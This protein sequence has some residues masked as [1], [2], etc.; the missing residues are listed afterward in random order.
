[1]GEGKVLG[2]ADVRV[3]EDSEFSVGEIV[4]AVAAWNRDPVLAG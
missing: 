1:M 4:A 3:E 2:V